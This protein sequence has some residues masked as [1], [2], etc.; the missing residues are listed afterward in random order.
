M[1]S[2]DDTGYLVGLIGSGIGTSLSPALHERE[3]DALG[4]RY[5]YRLLDLDDLHLP[6]TAVGEVVA[7]AR[8]AG[9]HGLN[10]THPVKQLV[11]AHLDDLSPDAA[12]V[13]AVNTVVFR[14]GRA[15]GHNTDLTGFAHGFR[16]ELPGV[17][18][19]SVVLL[20]AG[21]AGAAVAHAL[22]SLGV[23][24]LHVFDV[25]ARRT[26]RLESGLATR[27]GA[28]RVVQ[29]DS[30]NALA[31]AVRDADGL[32]HATPTGMVGRPGLPLPAELLRP[33]L[34]VAD[35]VYRPL[36]TELLALARERGCQVLSGGPMVV[37]QAADAFRLITGHAPDA[38][39]MRRHF[40]T[41]AH[42]ELVGRRPHA[43]R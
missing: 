34:W 13:G 25:D 28:G 21:G 10:I 9:Y 42:A 18:L 20:G 23:G 33:G 43:H 36:E 24:T 37:H 1:A 39:R 26:A 31:A 17:A 5:L 38:D 41:L 12:A 15:V 22:L 19:D 32:T 3:A 8:L 6:P 40:D 30:V 35:I 16:D 2:R 29:L 27:F 4:V 11:L 14:D 7:A